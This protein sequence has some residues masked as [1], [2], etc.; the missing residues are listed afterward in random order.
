MHQFLDYIPI[1]PQRRN[2]QRW[3]STPSIPQSADFTPIRP[4]KPAGLKAPPGERFFIAF[5]FEINP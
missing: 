3:I 1:S 5:I 2:D 4:P